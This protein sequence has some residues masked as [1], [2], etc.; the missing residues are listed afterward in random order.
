[1]AAKEL[2]KKGI[3][4]VVINSPTIK[5]LDEEKIVRTAKTCEAIVTVEEHQIAGGL[6][7]VVSEV[8]S[9]NYP[10][11]IEFVGVKDSFGESGKPNE[12]MKKYGLTKEDIIK[13][14]KEVLRRKNL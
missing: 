1:L 6:G 7:G 13:S 8:L 4:T 14:V 2:E 10:V 11:P 9:R 3:D 12:L 5:P